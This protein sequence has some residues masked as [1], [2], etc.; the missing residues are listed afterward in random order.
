[1]KARNPIANNYATKR[2]REMIWVSSWLYGRLIQCG[3][4]SITNTMTG[5]TRMAGY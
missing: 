1:M 2:M 5:T 4:Y 3:L